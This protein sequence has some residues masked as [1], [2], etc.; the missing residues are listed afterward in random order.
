MSAELILAC[1]LGFIGGSVFTI[2]L[3]CSLIM[4]L[5]KRVTI[6]QI[7]SKGDNE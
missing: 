3:L 2:L 1:V 7:N 4:L 5:V 6:G